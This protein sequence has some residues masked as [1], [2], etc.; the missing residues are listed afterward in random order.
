LLLFVLSLFASSKKSTSHS[1]VIHDVSL[2]NV[3]E[4][5]HEEVK[6]P[7]LTHR[8][9]Q[10]ATRNFTIP[11][12]VPPD[13]VKPEDKPPVN[14]D[15][16]N[17]KIGTENKDGIGDVVAPPV[18]VS[19]GNVEAPKGHAENYDSI[20]NIVEVEAQF[21]GGIDA[22]TKYL[23]RNLRTEV[24]IDNGAPEGSYTVVVSF[25]VDRDGNISQVQALNDPG[26]GTADEAIRVIKKSNQ[27]I[28]AL[29]NGN[30]VIY[31]QKQAITFVV[32]GQ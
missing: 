30:H 19:T 2:S 14:D 32:Q 6:A 22:W 13:E 11:R 24:P 20:F 9:Q 17:I 26:Y 12:I 1:I 8:V 31:R 18:E 7:A 25:L 28:P 3:D 4:P 15:L 23:Q 27:W 29:Q 21:P 5:H 16:D 10:V